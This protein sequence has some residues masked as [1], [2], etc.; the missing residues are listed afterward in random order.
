MS[1]SANRRLASIIV[2]CWNQIHFT[3]QCLAALKNHTRP[4]WEL[5]VVDNASTDET[6]SYLA[7]VRDMAAVPVTVVS[8]ATNLGFPAAINQGLQLARGEYLVMLNNDVVVTDGWLDQ[9]I[10]LAHAK[11]GST[12]GHAGEGG[13]GRPSVGYCA[14]SGDP[15]IAQGGISQ[16]DLIELSRRHNVTVIDLDSEDVMSE[17]DGNGDGYAVEPNAGA[18]QE[19]AHRQR[20]AP[21][22]L[23]GPMSNY[24]APPQLVDD[25][26]YC[27]MAAMPDFARQW[28]DEH[29]GQW[30]TAPKLS[31]FCLLIKRAVY[32]KIGGLDERFGLGFFDDDD[33]CE[34][35]RRAGFELAVAHDLFVHHFG[36]RS[37]AGNGIDAGK[38]LDQNA[39]RFADKW[40]LAGANGRPVALRPWKAVSRSHAKADERLNEGGEED[41]TQRRKD[42]KNANGTGSETS[43][44]LQGRV[45]T[46]RSVSEQSSAEPALSAS[47]LRFGVRFSSSDVSAAVR[48]LADRA[49]VS[50]TMIVR[51]EE[52]NLSQFFES[53]RGVFDEII[54]VDTGSK[55]RTIE[56]AQSFGAMVFEFAWVDSFSAAR[57]EALPHATGDYA[58]WL[59]ADD[60][61][62]PA[63]KEKLHALLGSPKRPGR[64]AG[65]Q[66]V[67]GTTM[68]AYALGAGLLTPPSARPEVSTGLAGAAHGPHDPL[69]DT[70]DSVS[71]A[72]DPACVRGQETP[73]QRSAGSGDPRTARDQACVR[74]QE[75]P[76]QAANLR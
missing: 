65:A 23:V 53:V 68:A 11:P 42:A 27:D 25:V 12:A 66:R 76:I 8:N 62:M 52:E 47:S 28:R 56:I 59:D 39:R 37:F 26:P 45:W 72:R 10:A 15:C 57:N 61:V 29:R 13:E 70:N 67:N 17:A 5:I 21:I 7:G 31:G 32:D 30:F 54:I 71:G 46:D 49:K 51:D 33:L 4:T 2:P 74:G 41:F 22:G 20:C 3:Q 58:F 69:L 1:T 36:S 60:V 63:E 6:A 43:S 38:L 55:D 34:R 40:G 9:L 24:A 50:L 73:I 35:A 18:S 48:D 64:G 75:T 14:G 44:E 19:A 16:A